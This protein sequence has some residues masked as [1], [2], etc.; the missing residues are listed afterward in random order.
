MRCHCLN[1]KRE[2]RV[3]APDAVGSVDEMLRTVSGAPGGA[4]SCLSNMCVGWLRAY[5]GCAGSRL[6]LDSPSFVDVPLLGLG[7]SGFVTLML[8]DQASEIPSLVLFSRLCGSL[9][10]DV[11]SSP[12]LKAPSRQL[13]FEQVGIP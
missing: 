5:D 10:C 12:L 6:F 11:T 4:P 3:G 8:C 1:S 2:Y 9:V 13:A 7:T